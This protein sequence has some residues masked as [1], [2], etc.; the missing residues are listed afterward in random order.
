MLGGDF[1]GNRILDAAE[2]ARQGLVPKVFVSG[3][4]G[5]YGFHENE[6][7]VP[8]AV[9]KGYPESLFIGLPHDAT[10]TREEARTVIPEL[11]RRGVH[12]L[13]IITSDFHSRRAARVFRSVAPDMEIAM[14]TVP[15]PRFDPHHW[16][17]DR[18]GR[19]TVFAEWTKTVADWMGGL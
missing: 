2:L 6:L 17:T 8:Y 9:R 5:F 14:V 16:W 12:V 11:R 7:A 15:T 18:E 4:L 13:D 10:S 19:K 3:P 1:Y